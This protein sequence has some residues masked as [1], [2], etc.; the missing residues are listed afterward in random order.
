MSTENRFQPPRAGVAD[1]RGRQ[2][3]QYQPVR[4]WSAAGRIGRLRYLGYLMGGYLVMMMFI[5]IAGAFAGATRSPAIITIMVVLGIIPY[6]LF[7]VLMHIQRAHDMGWSGWACLLAFIPLVGLLW[8]FKGGTT[9]ENKFGA[10]PPP[11]SIGVALLALL[12]PLAIGILAAVAL[13]AYQG[14]VQRAKAAQL[15]QQQGQQAPT[16]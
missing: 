1:V 15:N 7:S 12:P 9:G 16:P 8:V 10:P 13:P 4:I 5:G 3:S 11:N 6:L 2:S 14:Y